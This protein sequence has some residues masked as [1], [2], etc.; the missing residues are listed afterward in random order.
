MAETSAGLFLR[1]APSVQ[2]DASSP[3]KGAQEAVTRKKTHRVMDAQSQLLGQEGAQHNIVLPALGRFQHRFVA[4]GELDRDML[5]VEELG[6]EEHAL[7]ER[8][9]RGDEQE[10]FAGP[11]WW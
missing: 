4:D 8:V 1:P 5:K 9:D 3:R 11:V 2:A 6:V 10:S 7:S